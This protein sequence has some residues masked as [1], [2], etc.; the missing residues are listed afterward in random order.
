[1]VVTMELEVDEDLGDREIIDLTR[2]VWTKLGKVCRGGG[3][4]KVGEV[5]V[6]IKRIKLA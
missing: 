4:G 1:M 5:S 2:V 6:G 3:R